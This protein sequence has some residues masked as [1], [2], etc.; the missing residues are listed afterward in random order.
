MAHAQVQATTAAHAIAQQAAVAQQQQNPAGYPMV[1]SLP[2]SVEAGGLYAGL[3]LEEL[4]NYGGLDVSEAALSQYMPPEVA[5][6]IMTTGG[7][8][9]AAAAGA[10]A[11]AVVARPPPGGIAVPAPGRVALPGSQALVS[12]TPKNDVAM[13]RAEIKQGVR[14]IVLAKDQ[15]GKIGIAVRAIDKGVF[16]A[17]VWHGSAASLGGLRFGDQLLQINGENVAGWKDSKALKFLKKADGARITLAVRDRPWC[18]ALTL[19]KDSTN[20]IGFVFKKSEIT[21]IVKESSA[22]RNGLLIH[23]NIIEVNGQ[24]VVGLKD[25]V[26]LKI[27]QDSPRSIT[28][29]IMPSFV[30]NHLI[31]NIGFKRIKE[32]MEHGVPEY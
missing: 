2:P 8:A 31:K 3:G 26:I 32:F 4:M 13:M 28:L 20:H 6:A 19:V 7:A 11:G 1:S 18:R 16:V 15:K 23:H 29:T 9:S 12:I 24:N 10:P 30:Y 25:D 17:F 22:A 27:M 5:Q 21:A 14:Q